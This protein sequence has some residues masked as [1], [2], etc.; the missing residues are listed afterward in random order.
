[1]LR[2]AMSDEETRGA[3]AREKSALERALGI[4]TDV[5]AGE[6]P[7]ALLLTLNVFFVLTAYYVIKPVR[8]GLILAMPSGPQYKSYLGGAIAAALLVVV[9]LYGRA[10]DRFAKNKLVIG[11]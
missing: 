2:A 9:P 10:A 7:T 6:G 1:M 3:G 11:V 4:V 8:E 5:R